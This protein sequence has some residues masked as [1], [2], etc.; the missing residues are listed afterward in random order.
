MLHYS[1]WNVFA[2]TDYITEQ[3]V[4]SNQTQNTTI[5]MFAEQWKVI[6]A[7]MH[8]NHSYNW[9]QQFV[10][11]YIHPAHLYCTSIS[12]RARC[13]QV[14]N[15]NTAIQWTRST[16]LWMHITTTNQW[17][18]SF[19]ISFNSYSYSIL[20]QL[21]SGFIITSHTHT[22]HTHTTVLRLFGFYP[23]QPGWAG[24]RRNIHPLTPIVVINRLLSASSI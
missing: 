13:Q 2:K 17:C 4:H 9:F 10:T 8:T 16:H 18:F 15:N 21:I 7:T 6:K 1:G 11:R 20:T 5:C 23:R 19:D 12:R 14:I 3:A 24:T 22:P